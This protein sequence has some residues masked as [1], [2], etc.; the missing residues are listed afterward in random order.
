MR[1]IFFAFLMVALTSCGRYAVQLKHLQHAK[2][3]DLYEL[4]TYECY[5]CKKRRLM[6]ELQG[7]LVAQMYN[8]EGGR[9]D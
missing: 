1:Y 2:N 7:G 6:L 5:E 9:P 4:N 3:Y 8:C